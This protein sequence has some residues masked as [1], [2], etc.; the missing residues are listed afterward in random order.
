MTRFIIY[1]LFFLIVYPNLLVSQSTHSIIDN[2]E[3]EAWDYYHESQVQG[4]DVEKER[5]LL[6]K[7]FNIANNNGF[8]SL[9]IKAS[10]GLSWYYYTH[11]NDI[12]NEDTALYYLKVSFGLFKKI[13]LINDEIKNNTILSNIYN[14][15]NKLDTSY[16]Y[17]CLSDDIIRKN[18]SEIDIK[19]LQTHYFNKF[20]LLVD[21]MR[22]KEALSLLDL[23]DS[24]TKKINTPIEYSK[25]QTLY[26]RL[27]MESGETKEHIK[28]LKK[29]LSYHQDS[30]LGTLVITLDVGD[31]YQK[32]GNIDSAFVYYG[33]ALRLCKN[34]YPFLVNTQYYNLA[35]LYALSN[36]QKAKFYFN[37]LDTLQISIQ[38]P[39]LFSFL[40]AK[41]NSNLK[42]KEELCL[43][44]INCNPSLE[45]KKNIYQYLFDIFSSTNESRSNKYFVKLTE[46]KDSLAF[47]TR[48]SEIQKA[49]LK[50]EL[51]KK[52]KLLN[53]TSQELDS[54]KKKTWFYWLG[55]FI[56]IFIVF[57]I[58]L[59][60][61]Q[62]K[63]KGLTEKNDLIKEINRKTKL[64]E[65]AYFS[66]QKSIEFI[67]RTKKSIDKVSGLENLYAETNLY[68]KQI[69]KN[70][71][72]NKAIGEV[73]DEFFKTLGK[74]FTKT[75]KNII[76]LLRIELSSKEI[77]DVLNVKVSSIE[78]YRYNIRKKFSLDSGQ[79]LVNYIKSL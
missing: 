11:P 21:L 13:K 60:F 51:N 16:Y 10:Q 59:R 39:C 22:Y 64:I 18:K 38:L 20:H 54:L 62:R 6:L 2:E 53:S 79:S 8:D 32:L 47:K 52:E 73:K 48:E 29:A 15:R 1:I 76:I 75:E 49:I 77:A 44:A 43:K 55:I 34:E 30:S 57:V 66:N 3:K 35:D 5:K 63:K 27:Y 61:N 28:Y 78:K 67:K 9:L 31:A 7:S 42:A 12:S 46:I 19:I 37:K 74:K 23:I 68:L 58:A 65:E 71:E 26:A 69:E 4:I 45:I 25:L 24:N 56:L 40:K 41:I 72:F 33:K 14:D 36:P 70:K 17:S 50:R